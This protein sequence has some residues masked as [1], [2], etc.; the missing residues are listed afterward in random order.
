MQELSVNAKVLNDRYQHRAL[1]PDPVQSPTSKL[2][3]PLPPATP[4]TPSSAGLASPGIVGM[5]TPPPAPAAGRKTL[6][7]ASK[8]E[9]Y[10]VYSAQFATHESPGTLK[11]HHCC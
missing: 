11:I 5:V 7:D 9:F 8:G 2:S 3:S 4:Q 10:F 6:A 1:P